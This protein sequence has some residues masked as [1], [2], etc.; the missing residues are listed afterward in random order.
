MVDL[1]EEADDVAALAAPEAVPGTLGR[2]HV[3]GR[4]ALVVE[5]A[6]PLEAATTGR[7]ESD[8]VADDL[9]DPGLLT[10]EGD[11][12]VSNAPG[13][14][15]IL[16]AQTTEALPWWDLP[17]GSE[18]S[19]RSWRSTRSFLSIASTDSVLSIGSVGSV[20]S[21]GSIGSALSAFSVGSFLSVGSL[22]S[23]RSVLSVMSH[24]R[25]R[26]IR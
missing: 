1:A 14:A 6:D 13:H 15:L 22:M 2:A 18:T 8:V 16:G 9:V 26:A 19:A 3:E 25:R 5:R 10:Y 12:L 17:V 24:R 7:L 20:L 23:S 21:I 11:V 4:A